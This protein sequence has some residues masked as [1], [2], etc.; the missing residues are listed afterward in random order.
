[1]QHLLKNLFVLTALLFIGI[2]CSKKESLS[3]DASDAVITGFDL[4]E[5]GC[6]GGFIV[7]I[8]NTPPYSTSFLAKELPSGSNIN[9][10]SDFPV[11]V[12]IE[13]QADTTECDRNIIITRLQKK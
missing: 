4:T 1:M 2:N 5:C 9:S 7:N 6:C 10:N 3:P 13:W 12:K 8:V 11:Y